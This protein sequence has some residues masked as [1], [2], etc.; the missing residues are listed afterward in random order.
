MEHIFLFHSFQT[1][2]HNLLSARNEIIISVI[3]SKCLLPSMLLPM[4]LVIWFSLE[5]YVTFFVL[6]ICVFFLLASFKFLLIFYGHV[7]SANSNIVSWWSSSW[8]L[9]PLLSADWLLWIFF[10]QIAYFWW[11]RI[12]I[13]VS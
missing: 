2:L 10:Y 3:K 1:H 7:F 12:D 4:A 6:H 13:I 5:S 11:R 9:S 8:Y